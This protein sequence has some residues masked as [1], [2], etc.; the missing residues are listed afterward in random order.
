MYIP[1]YACQVLDLVNTIQIFFLNRIKHTTQYTYRYSNL[2]SIVQ[3]YCYSLF[4]VQVC[5]C[6]FVKKN[7]SVTPKQMQI[8]QKYL[9]IKVGISKNLLSY[10]IFI[11]T[12]INTNSIN[13]CS[14]FY[15]CNLLQSEQ[16][17]VQ[18]ANNTFTSC[19]RLQKIP[20][21]KQCTLVLNQ[22]IVNTISNAVP[23]SFLGS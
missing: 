14:I 15:S 3:G 16:L 4:N 19:I 8:N 18:S 12:Q 23:N 7:D 10:P 2:K 20:F 13:A 17:I 9:F 22:T 5:T 1:T 6:C 21:C 11:H